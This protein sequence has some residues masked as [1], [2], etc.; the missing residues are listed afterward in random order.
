[1]A[2]IATVPITIPAM[3]PGAKGGLVVVMVVFD[4][5]GEGDTEGWGMHVPEE[6]MA[7]TLLV[8]V[9]FTFAMVNSLLS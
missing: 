5:L 6:S 4:P 3:A 9:T 8:S 1:M 2:R 7:S